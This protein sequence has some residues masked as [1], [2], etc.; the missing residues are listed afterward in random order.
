MRTVNINRWIKCNWIVLGLYAMASSPAH[1][2]KV[3][4][5]GQDP[6]TYQCPAPY[7]SLP[8]TCDVT[9]SFLKSNGSSSSWYTS[10]GSP[11][12]VVSIDVISNDSQTVNEYS[13]S[14]IF[15]C[16]CDSVTVNYSCQSPLSQP[17]A[18]W[19][20]CQ[21]SPTY[22]NQYGYPSIFGSPSFN[23]PSKGSWSTNPKNVA[24]KMGNKSSITNGGRFYSNFWSNSNAKLCN[25]SCADPFREKTQVCGCKSGYQA[26]NV[27]LSDIDKLASGEM[28]PVIVG[29]NMSAYGYAWLKPANSGSNPSGLTGTLAA[30]STNICIRSCGGSEAVPKFNPSAASFN[31]DLSGNPITGHTCVCPAGTGKVYDYNIAGCKCPGGSIADSNNVCA[32]PAGQTTNYADANGQPWVEGTST[33]EKYISSCGNSCTAGRTWVDDL[34]GDGNANDG[35]CVCPTATPIYDQASDTCKSISCPTGAAFS[36]TQNKCVCENTTPV[37][38]YSSGVLTACGT[39]GS[40]ELWSSTANSGAG[41]CVPADIPCNSPNVEVTLDN[42]SKVCRSPCPGGELGDFEH[43]TAAA[44]RGACKC[45]AAVAD[46]SGLSVSLLPARLVS[47]ANVVVPK[48]TMIAE[49]VDATPS[50]QPADNYSATHC[51]CAAS[52]STMSPMP[53][54]SALPLPGFVN[55]AGTVLKASINDTRSV[56]SNPTLATLPD[57]VMF[58]DS[59]SISCGCPNFN[60]MWDCRLVSGSTRCGCWPSLQAEAWNGNQADILAWSATYP[61][62]GTSPFALQPVLDFDHSFNFVSVDSK[63]H[64]RALDGTGTAPKFKNS[65][66]R[67]TSNSVDS[68][69]QLENEPTNQTTRKIWKCANGLE[70]DPATGTCGN[71][72]WAEHACNEDAIHKDGYNFNSSV[73]SEMTRQGKTWNQVVNKKLA[74]CAGE[75]ASTFAKVDSAGTVT[76]NAST[77]KYSCLQQLP[78]KTLPNGSTAPSLFDEF[79]D[80]HGS[81]DVED[82]AGLSYPNR[83]Y[84]TDSGGRPI[85]GFFKH[86]GSRCDEKVVFGSSTTKTQLLGYLSASNYSGGKITPPPGHPECNFIVRAAL[87]TRCAKNPESVNSVAALKRICLQNGVQGACTANSDAQDTVRCPGASEIRVHY[88]I[89]D[90]GGAGAYLAGGSSSSSSSGGGY[91][92]SGFDSKRQTF[93]QYSTL[94]GSDAKSGGR[95]SVPVQMNR[96][97][98]NKFTDCVSGYTWSTATSSCVQNQ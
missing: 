54:P 46:Q 81:A 6:A 24:I 73:L 29:G 90:L 71:I 53:A 22:P 72:P 78:L 94:G 84:L 10:S 62:L 2:G 77:I 34:N 97:I 11:D 39:C 75:K 67:P 1:A 69:S 64:R 12:A 8:A 70:I 49:L 13:H 45:K 35:G 63:N 15:E 26:L 66:A 3:C 42:G 58:R 96:I 61:G 51:I 16:Q 86:D 40:G 95:S 82:T 38:T 87:E 85:V 5:A 48:A 31:K 57:L 79:Y 98:E 52:A 37:P 9:T 55:E 44:D 92:A 83:L 4:D 27:S 76:L 28:M 60:E 59:G 93:K 17:T 21:T 32:C 14:P 33:G 50:S 91:A 18:A 41:G 19:S 30:D 74:C 43:S 36:A 68:S 25:L 56:V 65:L 88:D 20:E 7:P 80:R 23:E 89:R 47:N